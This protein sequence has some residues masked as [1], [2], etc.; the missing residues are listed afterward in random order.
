MNVN[1]VNNVSAPVY[2]QNPRPN[3]MRNLSLTDTHSPPAAFRTK[4]A[5]I[6]VALLTLVNVLNFLDRQILA[7]LAEPI[8]KELNISD[9]QLGLL[10][11]LA[12]ALLYTVLGIR[13]AWIADSIKRVGLIAA[14]CAIW[15][16]FTIAS[17]FVT[18]F[19]QLALARIGVGVGVGESGASPPSYSV[20]SDHFAPSHRGLPLAIFAVGIP[21]GAVMG[22]MIGG[23]VAANYGWRTAFIVA[24]LP[25]ILVAL[26]IF[27]F[28]REPVRGSMDPVG[29]AMPPRPSMSQAI[30]D[31]MANRTLVLTA[32]SCGL[33]AFT[34][35]AML[36]WLP[37]YLIRVKGMTL[38]EIALYYSLAGG[39]SGIL[40]TLASGYIGDRLGRISKRYYP[41]IPAVGQLISLPFLVG[42]LLSPS[43]QMPLLFVVIP[44]FT[45]NMWLAP[46]MTLVQN[47]VAPSRRAISASIVLFVLNLIGLGLGPLYV[48]IISDLTKPSFGN[49]SLTVGLF[50]LFPVFLLAVWVQVMTSRTLPRESAA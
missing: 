19:T 1:D 14:A 17:A 10:T 30:R 40:G 25:G 20:I 42:F 22:S 46:L 27:L 11:G 2:H 36:N 45:N 9:T 43:W 29:T 13:V 3:F 4:S 15:S 24:G 39:V 31:F 33:C 6:V 38:S 7:I 26:L 37:T 47:T 23:A 8:S 28:I 12:F 49:E 34:G 21:I 44:S 35:Y 50:A 48:G 32:L 41:L 16:L 18:N 5:H